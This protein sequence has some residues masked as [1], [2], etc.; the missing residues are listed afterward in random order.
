MRQ[1]T[2]FGA[3]LKHDLKDA[4]SM[5]QRLLLRGGFIRPVA[6]G[7]FAFMPKLTR[8]L[9]SLSDLIRGELNILAFAS[10]DLPVLRPKAALEQSEPW[11]LQP[12][13]ALGLRDRRGTEMNLGTGNEALFAELIRS[14]VSSA[15]QLPRRVQLCCPIFRDEAGFRNCLL[16]LRESRTIQALSCEPDQGEAFETAR[17][18]RAM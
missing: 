10:C 11:T 9:D 4:P 13:E 8:V 3:T 2:L 7:H 1:S 14:D 16:R 12:G 17:A 5:A 15:R 6:S 18:V